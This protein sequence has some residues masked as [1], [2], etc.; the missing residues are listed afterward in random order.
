MSAGNENREHVV[1]GVV[2]T[3]P[4]NMLAIDGYQYSRKAPNI[5]GVFAT[6][7]SWFL[8]EVFTA[9]VK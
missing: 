3:K 9:L 8:E 4:S 2:P 1:F 7:L 6:L 5:Y